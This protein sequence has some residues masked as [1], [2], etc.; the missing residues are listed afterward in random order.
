MGIE[1]YNM[2]SEVAQSLTESHEAQ[3][4]TY[5]KKWTAYLICCSL[6]ACLSSFQ[7]GYNIGSANTIS[8][9]LVTYF[10]QSYYKKI[11]FDKLELFRAGEERLANGT[12]QYEEGLKKY[13]EGKELL[14]SKERELLAAEHRREN[15]LDIMFSMDEK[16]INEAKEY[17]V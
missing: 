2:S 10:E 16:K 3:T 11:F 17:K 14:E 6:I 12:A 4:A 15:Y 8:P 9:L 13:T 5:N 7:F 1:K